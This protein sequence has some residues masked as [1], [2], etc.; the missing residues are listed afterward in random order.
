V[1][2]VLR[3]HSHGDEVVYDTIR[4]RNA[5]AA[6][7]LAPAGVRIVAALLAVFCPTNAQ[8]FTTL[9]SFNGANGQG[10]NGLTLGP[11]GNFYGTT[12]YGGANDDGTVFKITPSGALTTLHSLSGADGVFPRAALTLGPD[13]NFYGTTASGGVNGPPG[14][15]TIFRITPSGVLT[16][17]YSFGN[18]GCVSSFLSSLVLGTDGN[19]YGTTQFGDFMSVS[20]TVF[21][22]T[23]TG[24]L[25]TLTPPYVFTSVAGGFEGLTLGTDGNFY[26]MAGVNFFKITPTGVLTYLNSFSGGTGTYPRGALTLWTEGN[27]YGSTAAGGENSSSGAIISPDGTIFKITPTGVLTTLHTFSGADGANPVAALTLGPDGNFYGT[28]A[29]GGPNFQSSCYAGFSPACA[30]GAGTIFKITPSGALTTLYTFSGGPDGAY[31][32]AALTLSSDGKFYGTTSTGGANNDGT[33]FSLDLNST[34]PPEPSITPGGIVP[35]FGT[36]NT[37]QQGEWVSIYGSNLAS[38]TT[39]W[40]G[41]FPTSLGGTSVMINGQVAYLSFVSPG[42][43]NL[44]VPDDTA[45]G[46]IPVLVT[47]AGGYAISTVTLSQFAPSFLLLDTKH[48]AGI[49]P[50]SNGSGAYG[51]GTYD[52]LGPTGSSLGYPTVAAKAGDVVELFSVGFGPTTPAVPA[53]QSFSGAAPTTNPVQVAISGRTVT[54]SF[55]GL[56]SAGVY[57]LNV[58]IPVGLGTGDLSLVASIILTFGDFHTQSGVVISLQ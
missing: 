22:I 58:T 50:R 49:I 45:T 36:V 23:P 53:G 8:T 7:T 39:V 42:Q 43:I 30:P 54:P 1:Y 15:A 16:T 56:S 27:F 55:A 34:A 3:Q 44:Q 57:Q 31:P 46:G 9:F 24:V 29:W 20:S 2:P 35:L 12:A 5:R 51:G 19:F 26:G 37:I 47:T 28:T 17:L 13:G 32:E 10:P 6:Y 33:I 48:V 4:S 25:T 40:N 11:D 38:G 41:N 18:C 14:N 52:I 21:K